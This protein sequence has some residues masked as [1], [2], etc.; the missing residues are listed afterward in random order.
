M[1]CLESGTVY[2]KTQFVLQFLYHKNH[3]FLFIVP[4]VQNGD[5]SESH[6]Y[7]TLLLYGHYFALPIDIFYGDLYTAT[8]I[9]V[10]QELGPY[11]IG[12]RRVKSTIDQTFTLR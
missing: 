7:E 10:K 9:Y 8:P 12:F 1:E 3:S 5:H 4:N 11:Q 2:K 6:N